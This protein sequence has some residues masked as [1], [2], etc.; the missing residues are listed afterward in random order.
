MTKY[1]EVSTLSMIPKVS[2]KFILPDFFM[3]K[4]D[5]IWHIW[6]N[7]IN[8]LVKKNNHNINTI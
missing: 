5:K 6:Y 2:G 8:K 3:P 4:I 7:L 1:T